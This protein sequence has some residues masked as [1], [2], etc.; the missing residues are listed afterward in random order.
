MTSRL[1]QKLDEGKKVL[2]FISGGSN[3]PITVDIMSRL[4]IPAANMTLILSDE[5][6]GEAGHQDSN[7]QQ[8]LQAGLNIKKVRTLATLLPGASLEETTSHQN[9]QIKN[10]L[11]GSDYVVAQFGIGDDG[12]VAGILPGSPAV[13][14]TPEMAV[15]YTTEVFDRITMTF[16][17]I[18]HVDLAYCFVYGSGK[19]TALTTLCTTEASPSEQPS[20]ILKRLPEVY[21][22][23]DQIRSEV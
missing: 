23:N 21:I 13:S 18:E 14:N 16:S 2:W 17:A 8:L 1:Q 7:W 6:Y 20:Q 15:G 22:Y 4:R 19:K 9:I 12:H 3:I 11:A 10:A 5:R